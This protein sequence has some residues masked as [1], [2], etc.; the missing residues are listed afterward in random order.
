MVVNRPDRWF[1]VEKGAS[2]LVVRHGELAGEIGDSCE[3]GEGGWLAHVL[4]VLHSGDGAV[5]AGADGLPTFRRVG[6]INIRTGACS[7]HWAEETS[8]KITTQVQNSSKFSNSPS[9]QTD[10]GT[11]KVRAGRWESFNWLRSDSQLSNALFEGNI[12][13]TK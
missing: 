4:Q 11:S 10:V 7:S 5:G 8:C 6:D 9:E 1:F 12:S 13:F 2:D 3:G